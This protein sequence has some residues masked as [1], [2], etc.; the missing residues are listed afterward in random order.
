VDIWTNATAS[1]APAQSV[2]LSGISSLTYTG[3]AGGDQVIVD[4]SAGDPLPASGLTFTGGSGSNTLEVIAAAGADTATVNGTTFAIT[5]PLGA[6]SIAYSGVTTLIFDGNN[7]GAD[8][9][10]QTAAP[11]GGANLVFSNPTSLD[12]LNINGGSFTVPAG[13]DGGGIFNYVLGTVSVAA[14]AKLGLAPSDTVTD[15]T[16]FTVSSLT[17][18]GA[19]D[20]TDNAVLIN[21]G[22]APNDPV[23]T[24]RSDLAAA[25]TAKYS[26]ATLAISSSIAA[27]NPGSFVIGYV[28]TPAADQLKFALTVPGDINLDY[29]VTFSDFSIVSKDYGQSISKGNSVSWASG[30]VNYDGQVTFA[31]LSIV[32]KNLGDT[33]AKALAALMPPISQVVTPAAPA[34]QTVAGPAL[35]ASTASASA[36]ATGV[37]FAATSP[38][39]P[40]DPITNDALVGVWS[41]LSPDADPFHRIPHPRRR[42]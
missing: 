8:T 38:A 28:D 16:V 18:N 27:A 6:A 5:T 36:P 10:T 37:L 17:V 35:A 7:A 2:L 1:G 20:I 4:F 41:A 9:L 32:S 29:S 21:Y 19:L 22:S 12:T 13:P 34:P 30:D 3:P 25:Y 11:G 40:T 14:G 42:R 23:A 31:D 24:I 39:L 26:G 15:Q 33:L